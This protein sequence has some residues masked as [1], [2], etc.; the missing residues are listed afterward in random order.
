MWLDLSLPLLDSCVRIA[1]SFLCV[2]PFCVPA[3]ACQC[4]SWWWSFP[5]A[6]PVLASPAIVQ[7]PALHCIVWFPVCCSCLNVSSAPA[8]SCNFTRLASLGPVMVCPVIV[9]VL[10]GMVLPWP[11]PGCRMQ[12]SMRYKRRNFNWASCAPPLPC[13]RG[14]LY[15]TGASAQTCLAFNHTGAPLTRC[16]PQLCARE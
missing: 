5:F 3:T 14:V 10:R 13:K 1:F 8:R 9:I 15:N 12:I 7:A 2:T 11:S 16:T 6:L 4:L